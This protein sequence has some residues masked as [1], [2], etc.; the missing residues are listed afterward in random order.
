MFKLFFLS[1]AVIRF[2]CGLIVEKD[3]E[4]GDYDEELG[5]C[6]PSHYFVTVNWNGYEELWEVSSEFYGAVKLGDEILK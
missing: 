2:H 5:A 3:W 4:P 6:Y 1:I